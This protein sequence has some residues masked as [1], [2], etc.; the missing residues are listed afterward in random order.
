[1]LIT[2]VTW[3]L[4]PAATPSAISSSRTATGHTPS[5][6]PVRELCNGSVRW[7]AHRSAAGCRAGE[8]LLRRRGRLSVNGQDDDK[9]AVDGHSASRHRASTPHRRRPAAPRLM[10]CAVGRWPI[11]LICI[12]PAY[13]HSGQLAVS[14]RLDDVTFCQKCLHRVKVTA[15]GLCTCGA[16]LSAAPS[17]G[18]APTT[19]VP[20]HHLGYV[21]WYPS[22]SEPFHPAEPD[23]PG[24]ASG[25]VRRD[26]S[27]LG[28]DQH[29]ERLRAGKRRGHRDRPPHRAGDPVKQP[30][31]A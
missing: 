10:L 2:A 27:R 12:C 11:Q 17:A 8:R 29:G 21:P 19:V 20:A 13:P 5:V 25:P 18:A 24:R 9:A 1:M 23:N 30:C 22:G 14:L 4:D 16:V 15:A 26:D 31:L 3:L 7:A 6:C 28:P